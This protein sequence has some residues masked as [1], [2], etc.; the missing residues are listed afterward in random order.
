MMNDLDLRKRDLDS[1][2][3]LIDELI[4]NK[5]KISAI[6]LAY[7]FHP[8]EDGASVCQYRYHGSW[9]TCL[10]II[11]QFYYNMRQRG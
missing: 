10:G 7:E 9:C 11:S 4:E 2:Q 5:E 3:E 6:S 8:E 1:I